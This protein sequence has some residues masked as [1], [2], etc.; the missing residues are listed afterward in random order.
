MKKI[1]VFLIVLLIGVLAIVSCGKKDDAPEGLQTADVRE[2]GGYI[3]FAPENWAVV[4]TESISAAKVSA[5]NNTSITFTEAAMPQGTLPEYFDESMK[6]L[7]LGITEYKLL[8]RDEKCNFG[9]ADGECLKYVYSYKYDGYDFACMQILV[10][11]GTKF[12]I[13]TYTSYG[14]VS[15]ESSDYR[16][17][18]DAVQLSIDSFL[19]TEAKESSETVTYPKDSDG[20]NMVSDKA[21]S[22]FEL[23][24]PADYEVLY[25]DGYVKAKISGGANISL[26]KA[27]GT[28]IDIIDYLEV[29]KEEMGKFATDLTDLGIAFTVDI[30]EDSE[31]MKN[32]S[33]DVLPTRDTALRLGDLDTASLAAYE[34]TYV[35]GGKTYHVYQVLGVDPGALGLFGG[36]GYVFTYTALEDEYSL[37]IDEI[38]TILEKVRF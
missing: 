11:N 15:S 7:P 36:A 20:Y 37:H 6:A 1:S 34:Y 23:Y 18:L 3:F 26:S 22:G 9:N 24:L 17:Y 12:Y 31:I 5:I 35:F 8:L 10:N 13:F 25:S 4:N 28:G 16:K 27:T 33:F 14:S 32:W 30:P 2:S 19:F 29:R 38:K 21:L